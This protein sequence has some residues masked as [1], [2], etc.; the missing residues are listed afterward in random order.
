MS[1]TVGGIGKNKSL[2]SLTMP[3]SFG[4]VTHGN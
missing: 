3:R 2:F 1:E 4:N